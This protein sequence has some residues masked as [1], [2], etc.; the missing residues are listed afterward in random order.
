MALTD[1][2]KAVEL[3]GN[4][5]LDNSCS[6][7]DRCPSPPVVGCPELLAR[8]L[9]RETPMKSMEE[10]EGLVTKDGNNWEFTL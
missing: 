4:S 6:C 8:T 5:S 3:K 9:L 1:L 10:A 7:D 2:D